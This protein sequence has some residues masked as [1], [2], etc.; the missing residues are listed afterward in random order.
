MLKSKDEQ[1]AFIVFSHMSDIVPAK[2]LIEI[3]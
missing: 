3:Q 1:N 2:L